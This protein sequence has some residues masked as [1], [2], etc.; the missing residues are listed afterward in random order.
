M[1]VR[2]LNPFPPY[3]VPSTGALHPSI[4]MPAAASAGATGGGDSVSLSPEALA[5]LRPDPK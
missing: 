4:T 1:T 3:P 5:L 2:G